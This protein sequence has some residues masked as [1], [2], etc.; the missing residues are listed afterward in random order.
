[1][2]ILWGIFPSLS[3][4]WYVGIA[5]FFTHLT[6]ASVTIYLHRCQ[7]HKSIVLHSVPSHCFRA[8]LWL[9]T[10]M[11]TKEWKAIH[12]KHHAKCETD[13]DP[14]SPIAQMAKAKIEGRARRFFWMCWWVMWRGVRSYVR[15]SHIPETMEKYGHGAPDDWMERNVYSRYPKM[16]IVVMAVIDIVLFGPIAGLPIWF[17]QMAWIP[18]TAAGIIN[19]MGHSVGYRNFDCPDA[20]TNIFPWGILIGGEELHNNHHAFGASPKLS[21]ARYEFDIGWLYI[22]L[23]ERCSLVHIKWDRVPE[24]LVRDRKRSV[25]DVMTAEALWKYREQVMVHFRK[26][27]KKITSKQAEVCTSLAQTKHTLRDILWNSPSKEA[28]MEAIHDWCMHAEM[29]HGA[30]MLRF[31]AY[32]KSLRLKPHGAPRA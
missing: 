6:I 17:V 29:K 21:N 31:T 24:R 14:H 23:L 8:W 30:R 5:F 2:D 27:E 7:A 1:M 16:G 18:V 26:T 28:L 4:W 3:A 32:I 9:T 12:L 20:S 10:G 25:I 15:E 11:V 13:D 19:G 22:R